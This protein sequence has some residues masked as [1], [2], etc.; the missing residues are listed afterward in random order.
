[1][2][3]PIPFT[4]INITGGFWHARQKLNADTTITAVMN[5]FM[6]TGRFAAAD[7][8]WRDG[9]PM[10]P[11]IFWDSDIAKWMESVAYILEKQPMPKLEK[12]VEETIDAFEAN[13]DKYGYINSYFTSVEPA[14]RWTR[15]SDHELYCAGH[16]IEAAVAWKHATG[17]DRF[18][19][20]MC[21]YADYIEQVFV[22]D[23]S[24]K[25]TTPGHEEIELAL[26]KLYHATGE[27]RY[28]EL[29]KFFIDKRGTQP[30]DLS[31][32]KDKD[33]TKQCGY[34]QSHLPVREQFEA[35]GH[36]VRAGY[37]YTAMADIAREYGDEAL[38]NA[39]RKLFDNIAFRRMYITGGVG[40]AHIGETYTIDYDLP[41]DV[42]YTE[43]CAAISL[44]YFARRMSQLEA[45]AKYAD[46]IERVLYNGFLS[47][48]SL[49]GKHFFYTNPLEIDVSRHYRHTTTANTDWLPPTQRVEVFSCSCCPP[50][51]TRFVASVGDYLY[52]VNDEA[53]VIDQYMNSEA[54]HE[55]IHIEVET[56]YPVSGDIK[57][58]VSGLG[59]RKLMLR[60]PSWC[61]SFRLNTAYTLEKGYAV[62]ENADDTGILLSLDMKPVLMQGHPEIAAAAG[63]VCVMRG[64]VVYCLEGQD[65]G[66]RLHAVS[67]A[68]DT[69]FTEE[70]SDLYMMPVL[71]AQGRRDITAANDW[72]YRPYK[73]ET[74]D[75]TLTF[76]PYYAFANR[77]E[78]DMA[79]W[80]RV[81]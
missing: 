27:K 81:Y 11:H 20:M 10:K 72:L 69:G 32:E 35:V 1:M 52:S 71:K 29:S 59:N 42:A 13:Q 77:G 68:A 46:V 67:V 61:A 9:D 7:C 63:K 76:I 30:E 65:N 44:A 62:I 4:A 57:L 38:A 3:T 36:S 51:I 74:E 49:D 55:G 40:S 22:K 28:L 6:D 58:R 37:L 31:F 8:N 21:R 17:R 41:N 24:A 14:A 45:D 54:S 73:N 19:K 34:N 5:R 79:V 25:F 75:L 12:V 47:G 18:L 56:D 2:F 26:V 53:V 80:V 33:L 23:G 15:R 16:L 78:D 60:I 48:T 50:N 43:T 66:G 70:K 39:C 64:P